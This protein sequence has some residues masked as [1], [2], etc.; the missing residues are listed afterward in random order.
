MLRTSVMWYF[1][2]ND[3]E[4]EDR[5]PRYRYGASTRIATPMEV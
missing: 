4:A 2:R 3:G 1:V 5:G